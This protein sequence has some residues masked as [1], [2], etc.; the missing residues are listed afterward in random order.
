MKGVLGSGVSV[1][2]VGALWIVR[3]TVVRGDF[4]AM[5]SWEGSC[6]VG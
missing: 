4:R 1:G 5:I 2:F 3:G 6:R